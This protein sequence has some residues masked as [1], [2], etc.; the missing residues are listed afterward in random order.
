[1]ICEKPADR[2]ILLSR[3]S[4]PYAAATSTL[5]YSNTPSLRSPGF[6]DETKP[7][8]EPERRGPRRSYMT[9]DLI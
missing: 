5:H 6:E 7:I 8:G 1:M 4:N 3:I 9:M 2:E